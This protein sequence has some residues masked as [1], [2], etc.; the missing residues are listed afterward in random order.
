M[1]RARFAG[2]LCALAALAIAPASAPAKDAN[3]SA[4]LRKA[5]TVNGIM[6][7]E[8][9]LQAIA[10]RNDGTRASGTDGYQESVDYVAQRLRRAGYKV[11]VQPFDFPFFQ[12]LRDPDVRARLAHPARVHERRV[13][14]HGL[15]DC[16][17]RSGAPRR[18][19]CWAPSTTSRR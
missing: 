9:A 4:K 15:T 10:D 3:A 12:S 14:A 6:E 8:R 19:A 16:G 2:L 5:V 18:R 17:S 11:T 1:H 13:R 7:H